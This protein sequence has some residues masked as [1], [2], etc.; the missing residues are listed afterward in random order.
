VATVRTNPDTKRAEYQL[1]EKKDETT[2]LYM[3]GKWFPE[4]DVRL[5]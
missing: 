3:N 1:K 5:A 2:T 4:K